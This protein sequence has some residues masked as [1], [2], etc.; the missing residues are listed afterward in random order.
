MATRPNPATARK[1]L[2]D[3]LRHL[4]EQAGQTSAR[5]AHTLGWSESKISRIETG[6]TVR[7]SPADLDK[8][9]REY[10]VDPTLRNELEALAA[11]ANRIPRPRGRGGWLPIRNGALAEPYEEFIRYEQGA[12]AIVDY[13]VLVVPGLLQTDEYARAII[14]ADS[15]VQ[16]PQSIDQKVAARL[17]RQVVL[18]RQPVPPDFT[19]FMDEAVL[20]R[21]VGGARVMRRQIR[22]LIAAGERSNVAIRVLPFALGA[23]RG[24]GGS[25]IMLEMPVES[26]G[27]VVYAEG[28]TGGVLRSKP[29]EVGPYRDSLAVINEIALSPRDSAAFL[30]AAADA[31]VESNRSQARGEV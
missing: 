26:G 8:L 7:I 30:A 17:A 28:V 23:H 31:V 18:T 27:T 19:F 10:G 9:C 4:R 24:L 11:Q 1:Q 21:P 22:Q 6:R 2:G 3:K 29:D 14:E 25:F 15:S 5:V 13:E 16:E 12:L 20:R